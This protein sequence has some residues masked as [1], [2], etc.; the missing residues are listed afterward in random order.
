VGFALAIFFGV[1]GCGTSGPN[2]DPTAVPT[3]S[4]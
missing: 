1:S 4:A 3:A 2:G